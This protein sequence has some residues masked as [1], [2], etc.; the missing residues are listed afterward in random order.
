[1]FCKFA[2]SDS[3]LFT[4]LNYFRLARVFLINA[5][6][7]PQPHNNPKTPITKN[8]SAMI[9]IIPWLELLHSL[10]YAPQSSAKNSK[11]QKSPVTLTDKKSGHIL[12]IFELSIV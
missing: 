5:I 11:H 1:M 4:S 9:A 10:P 12:I 3:L 8:I 7:Q 2:R 6:S